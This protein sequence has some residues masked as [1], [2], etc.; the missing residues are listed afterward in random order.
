MDFGSP[1]RRRRLLGTPMAMAAG[2]GGIDFTMEDVLGLERWLAE[3]G[4]PLSPMPI[5][6]IGMRRVMA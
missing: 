1:Q 3:K 4:C 6:P 5:T 2:H